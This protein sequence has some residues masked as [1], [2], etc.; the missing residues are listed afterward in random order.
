M[1]LDDILA[2]KRTELAACAPAYASWEPPA[3]PPVRRDFLPALRA[4]GI[5]LLAEFKRRSPSKGT[6]RAEA[7]PAAVACAYAGAGAAA[8]SVLTDSAFFGGSYPDLQRARAACELPVL[9]KDFLI[10]PVQIAAS[11]GPDGPDC[12]LLIAAALTT[13]QLRTLR[14]L[15]ARCGQAC[16]VE[17][18]HEAELDRALES[19]AELIGINNRDLHTFRVTLNTTLR[20]RPRVPASIPVVAESGIHTREDVQ[21]LEA[22][23]VDAMLVGEALMTAPDPGEKIRELLG[24]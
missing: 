4:P 22:A 6:L 19:G 24:R 8:L 14:E 11:A 2:H 17:V 5:S 7:D 15:A 23:G 13:D 18:H 16:L 9:R 20:L 3:T 1:I 21:R 12:L 10:D